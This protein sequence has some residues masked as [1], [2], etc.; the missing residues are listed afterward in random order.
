MRGSFQ[1]LSGLIYDNL[2]ESKRTINILQRMN[3][4][5]EVFLSVLYRFLPF[6]VSHYAA[7]TLETWKNE[8]GHDSCQKVGIVLYVFSPSWKAF[9]N[10]V[11][12]FSVY[13]T[14][15]GALTSYKLEGFTHLFKENNS[16]TELYLIYIYR[17]MDVSSVTTI[18]NSRK[19]TLK[20]LYCFSEW[21]SLL[22]QSPVLC[23]FLGWGVQAFLEP[24]YFYIYTVF[25]LQAVY[26]MALYLTAWLLSGSWLAGALSGIWYI[27]NR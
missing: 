16:E 12:P 3:I 25:S 17:W 22:T 4:Y 24:V 20:P 9:R 11:F 7:I 19:L 27:L 8:K 2:T 15:I 21:T 5:Q 6:Q 26:V 14:L 18:N 1:G 13:L 23:V 10:A